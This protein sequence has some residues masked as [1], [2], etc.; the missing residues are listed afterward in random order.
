MPAVES[1]AGTRDVR[2]R[3]RFT[4]LREEWA[5]GLCGG[6]VGGTRFDTLVC[7]GFLPLLASVA[8]RDG[9][10]RAIWFHWFAGDLP[11][12]VTS[13]LR[14]LGVF[15]GRAQPACH[16]VAQGLLGWLIEREAQR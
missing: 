15:S 5:A 13:G 14:E 2:R 4:A 3:H 1:E 11:P 6:V 8:E 12:L 10:R 16:G 9:A 7:D